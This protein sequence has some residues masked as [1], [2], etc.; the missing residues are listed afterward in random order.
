MTDA[1]PPER[2]RTLLDQHDPLA[3]PT[4]FDGLSARLA[5]QAGFEAVFTSGFGIAASTLGMPDM[6]LLTMREN[7]DRVDAIDNAVDV[8]V[9]ADMD[10]G[11]GSALNV[12]RTVTEAI[13]AGVAGLIIE[14]QEWPKKCGH[15]DEKRVV[16]PA[17]G[18]RRIAAAA[19]VRDET[20]RNV[21]IVGRTDAR[22]PHGLDEAIERGRAYAAAGADVVFVEAP[23]SR[24]EL[25][26]IATEIDARTF[27]NVVA[28]GKTPELGA[29]E[30]GDIGFDVVAHTLPAL[31]AA[32][33]AMRDA[34]ETLA[35]EGTSESLSGVSFEAFE[36]IVGAPALREQEL[37]YAED[38]RSSVPDDGS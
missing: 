10:T 9:I 38:G 1:T 34:Y 32:T 5:E 23:A 22:E 11:Y 2:L 7:V 17:E 28:D 37:R 30:L 15:M 12:R 31:F 26:R 4:V 13:D 14:D 24:A 25:E 21:V 8:P 36:E 29:D 16:T 18:R 19:D 3:M 6:G 27:A 33:E 20:G 35:A